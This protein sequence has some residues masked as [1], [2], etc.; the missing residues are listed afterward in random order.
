MGSNPD[1]LT[2]RLLFSVVC[3]LIDSDTRHHSGQNPRQI[4]TI[5]MTRIAVEKCTDHAK[6][7][8]DLFFFLPL[9][10]AL[11]DTLTRAALSGPGLFP[12]CLDP[13]RQRR[14]VSRSDCEI[15]SNCGKIP[16][17]GLDF[18]IVLI[19][20]TTAMVT[21]TSFHLHDCIKNFTQT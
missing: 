20:M 9:K 11:R 19:S 16:F 21:M 3:T 2:N 1:E 4:L 13:Y 7:H 12:P 15:S 6:P 10:K 14:Q 8:F 18:A 5:V 17:F